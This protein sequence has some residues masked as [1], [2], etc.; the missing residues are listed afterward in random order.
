M[1]TGILDGF[2]KRLKISN[3]WR[4]V[5]GVS[6]A[7]TARA[8]L[9]VPTWSYLASQTTTSGSSRDFTIPAGAQEIELFL[10][11]LSTNGS[12]AFLVQIGDAGGIESTGYQSVGMHTAA[13][14]L[15]SA[16][17]T[18]G[19]Q[20]GTNTTASSTFDG[21]VRLSLIN[22]A[23]FLWAGDAAIAGSANTLSFHMSGTKALSQELTTVRFTSVSADTFDAGAVY[24][25]WR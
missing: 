8:T 6:D 17:N 3:F 5:L 23:T 2:G 20:I 10:V 19:F 25:R 22:P 1:N 14:T 21:L 18:T 7:A 12:S 15:G 13:S 11:G 9:G 24:C 4:T 16:A